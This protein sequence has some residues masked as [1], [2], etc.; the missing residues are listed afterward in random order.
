LLAHDPAFGI[1]RVGLVT[2]DGE[3]VAKGLI[4]LVGATPE[5]FSAPGGMGLIAKLD[6]D[7]TIE[8]AQKVLEKFPNGATM[9]GGMVDAGY[10]KRE[11]DKL[12]CHITFKAGELLIN[13]KPQAIPGLGGPPAAAMEESEAPQE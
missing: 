9:A 5:D 6:A 7:I 4:K 3:I 8:A 11:G 1:D 10:A 13:G 2:P 12:V